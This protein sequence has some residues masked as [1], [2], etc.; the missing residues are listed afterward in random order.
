MIPSDDHIEQ[1]HIYT[2]DGRD[3]WRI[4]AF[5][6]QPTVTMQNIITG[7]REC[8]GIGGITATKFEPIGGIRV[9][10]GQSLIERA[11]DAEAVP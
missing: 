10:R 6:D 8:F 9:G 5:C 7:E 2:K 1:R 4:I 11:E 3:L